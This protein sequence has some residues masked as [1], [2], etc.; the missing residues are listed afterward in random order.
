MGPGW[1]H[2][3]MLGRYCPGHGNKVAGL[4]SVDK[5]TSIGDVGS[6][7]KF[8]NPI[9]MGMGATSMDIGLGVEDASTSFGVMVPALMDTI[10]GTRSSA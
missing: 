3:P 7:A 6:G 5:G 8:R 4:A 10:F 2:R 1:G 9:L